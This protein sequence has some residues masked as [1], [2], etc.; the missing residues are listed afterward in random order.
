MGTLPDLI[1]NILTSCPSTITGIL[2]QLPP[3]HST[4]T[5]KKPRAVI[6]GQ[7]C[8]L[9][10]QQLVEQ[11]GKVGLE[12]V[13]APVEQERLIIPE[14][15]RQEY[16]GYVDTGEWWHFAP[17]LQEVIERLIAAGVLYDPEVYE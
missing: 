3:D 11:D 14:D 6:R 4:R 17:E 16:Q 5:S 7:L 10:E 1:L 8:R 12:K 13:W 9:R 15:F 2:N